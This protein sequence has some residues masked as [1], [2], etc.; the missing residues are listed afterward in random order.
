MPRGG[1]RPGSGP[2]ADPMSARSEARGLSEIRLPAKGFRGRIPRWPLP[3]RMI[4]DVYF[5][6][7][8]RIK[9]FNEDATER[10]ADRELELWKQLWRS[11]QAVMWHREPWRQHSVAHFVRMSVRVEGGEAPAADTAAMLRLQDQIGLT[12][13]GMRFNGWAIDSDEVAEKR[14]TRKPEDAPK[15]ERRLRAVADV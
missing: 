10:I 12:P 7:K 1:A 6:E 11:P 5:I 14:Q 4:Y 9:E 2:A 8:E 3:R 13:G 15:P